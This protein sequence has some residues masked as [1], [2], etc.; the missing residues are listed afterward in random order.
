M[1]SARAFRCCLG[2]WLNL[3]R[4]GSTCKLGKEEGA[5]APLSLLL[6]GLEPLGWARQLSDK[7]CFPADCRNT[8]ALWREQAQEVQELR[9]EA[10]WLAAEISTMMKV[11]LHFGQEGW[12]EQGSTQGPSW[13]S[14]W[15]FPAQPTHPSLARGCWLSCSTVKPLLLARSDVVISLFL[16]VFPRNFSK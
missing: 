10:A 11:I 14:V 1:H 5:P 7:I 15:S 12:D 2:L 9:D 16:S 13:A 6:P 3:E 4:E 8:L